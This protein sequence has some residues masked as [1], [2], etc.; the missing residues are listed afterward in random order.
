MNK[1]NDF[2][3]NE[4]MNDE[5]NLFSF[6]EALYA[7]ATET[8]NFSN[9][10]RLHN[11]LIGM[12]S[13]AE[14]DAIWS[15][16]VAKNYNSETNIHR[17]ISWSLSEERDLLNDDRRLLLCQ[18]IIW[19]FTTTNNELRDMATK[20]L[21]NQLINHIGII[22]QLLMIFQNIDEPYL[23]E[24]LWAAAYGATRNSSCFDGMDEL[25]SWVYNYFFCRN[26]VYPNVLV[27]DY[28][29]NII[30][31]VSELSKYVPKDKSII[32]PPYKSEFPKHLP[33]NDEIDRLILKK[34]A[35]NF[36][37]REVLDKIKSSMVTEYGRGISMYGDF[38]RYVFQA[39]LSSWD[40]Q[41]I[42]LLSNYGVWLI[43][44]KYGYDPK[45]FAEF[46]T[47]AP[48]TSSRYPRRRYNV[49]RIGKKYQW[50][51][52]YEIAALLSDNFKINNEDRGKNPE[53]YVYFS[54]PWEPH[55]RNI[56]PTC[57]WQDV[58]LVT[59]PNGV[60]S[61]D[62]FI[63][64]LDNWSQNTKDIP[65]FETNLEFVDY[66]GQAW[67]MLHGFLAWEKH[68]R[69]APMYENITQRVLYCESASFVKPK[70]FADLL[71]WLQEKSEATE[72]GHVSD[73]IGVFLREFY[74]SPAY[75]FFSDSYYYGTEE[76]KTIDGY[77]NEST[78]IMPVYDSYL[79]ESE[80]NESQR[81][82]LPCRRLYDFFHLYCG[83][84]SGEWCSGNDV[85]CKEIKLEK[86]DNHC[87]L[88]KKDKLL[89]FL[90]AENLKIV[91]T[92][93]AEK[94]VFGEGYITPKGYVPAQISGAYTLKN[95][96]VSGKYK[97]LHA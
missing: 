10:T 2:I 28:A 68:N 24:R 79:C 11:W 51:A 21:V 40:H 92:C 29:R 35:G 7:V 66:N 67:Y 15:Q 37:W 30:E 26:K 48:K 32:V 70:G 74:D 39:L 42:Q 78:E 57:L 96:K 72:L 38:G 20:A 34:T 47:Y 91:W 73:K 52:L 1:V 46:D 97:L 31:Y 18:A 12:T 50:I 33:S 69:N 71:K 22:K 14:R 13:M 16:L 77:P 59:F 80:S 86:D 61:Y 94:L 3:M 85:I 54:G 63:E 53:K 9:A 76:W 83:K 75:E 89:E 49:E 44:N 41:D 64:N 23:Q 87:L 55:F 36:I 90:K 84:S 19:L 65:N 5:E 8:N 56:D 58:P 93:F 81:F 6:I 4:I 27:R 95:K 60:L 43:L 17:L 45:L 62:S 25:G 82:I 88:I